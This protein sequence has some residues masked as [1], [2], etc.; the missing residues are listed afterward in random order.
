VL[1]PLRF[2]PLYV[3]KVWGDRRLATCLGRTLP[4]DRR[5]G[6]SWEV[7][8]HPHGES[9]LAN[10]PLRGSSFRELMAREGEALLGAYVLAR[11]Y[12]RFPLLV[13]YIDADDRLSVQVHPDDA[14]A[15]AHAGEPGKTEMWYILHAAPDAELIAG[16]C[17]GVT[18]EDVQRALLTGDPTELL[19]R[20]PVRAGDAVFIP[21]GRIHALL[22]GLLALEIQQNSDTTYRLFDWH[23][24]GL[25]GQPR[26][27]HVEQALA[28]ADWS[29]D[30]AQ[31]VA[32][33]IESTGEN[34]RSV[35]AACDYFAVEK[36]YLAR[37]HRF[38]LPGDRFSILNCVAGAGALVWSG[39]DETLRIGDTVLLPACLTEFTL[40]PDG[41]AAFLISSVP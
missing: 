38:V 39:G 5:I 11:G 26:Q 25:D 27:L 4:P 19:H 9:L 41:D 6:E 23:R 17:E 15:L 7:A 12:D 1:Y 13:K 33:Q 32:E 20:F 10:G 14:Y 28:A 8:D 37:E 3:E 18:R 29:D 22:P 24:R 40:H 36:Y 31:P 16:L 35:L 2:H 21:A 30:A 34:R